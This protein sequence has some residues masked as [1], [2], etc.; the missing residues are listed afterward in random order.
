VIPDPVGNTFALP[1]VVTSPVVKLTLLP[2]T[3]T[4]SATLT[5]PVARLN[6]L[7]VTAKLASPMTE[8]IPVDKLNA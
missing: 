4:T 3:P 8:T 7:P 5:A 2:E 1:I 6:L